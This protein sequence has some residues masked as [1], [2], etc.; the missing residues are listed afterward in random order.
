[1]GHDLPDSLC[2]HY[3]DLIIANANKAQ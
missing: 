1:M 2:S 3:A